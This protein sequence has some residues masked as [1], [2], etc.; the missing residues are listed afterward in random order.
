MVISI[1]ANEN[2]GSCLVIAVCTTTAIEVVAMNNNKSKNTNNNN[3]DYDFACRPQRHWK[4]S[5]SA[6]SFRETDLSGVECSCS[7]SSVCEGTTSCASHKAVQLALRCAS[8]TLLQ[9][10][11]MVAFLYHSFSECILWF[12]TEHMLVGTAN[13]AACRQDIN[14]LDVCGKNL[15]G[16]WSK[17]ALKDERAMY[18]L[19][20]FLSRWRLRLTSRYTQT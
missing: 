15:N 2:F 18:K 16:K 9:P 3:N 13:L 10:S 19:T 11:R 12:T 6:V 8:C 1:W 7:S 17:Y 4:E 14:S 5:K 20:R